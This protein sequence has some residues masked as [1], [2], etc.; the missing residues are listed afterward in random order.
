LRV[1]VELHDVETTI[2]A[3]RD[4]LTTADRA[5]VRAINLAHETGAREIVERELQA[6][7]AAHA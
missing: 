6:L 5:A 1:P 3:A 2:E 4:A 7:E